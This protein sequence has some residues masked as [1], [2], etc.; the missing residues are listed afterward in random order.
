MII[1]LKYDQIF[2]KK[3]ISFK[4]HGKH[5]KKFISIYIVKENV[6][7]ATIKSSIKE[8]D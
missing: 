1:D 5:Q 7:R 4:S 6:G 8:D 2:E 3:G